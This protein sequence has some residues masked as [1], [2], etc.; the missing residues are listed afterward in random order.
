MRT[1]KIPRIPIATNNATTILFLLVL[2]VD[3]GV[4]D[5]E[6]SVGSRVGL[7]DGCVEGFVLGKH[8]GL[9]VGTKLGM[10]DGR[11]LG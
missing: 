7:T 9:K 1:T 8:D 4:F 2:S 3:T 10:Q 5:D 11:P 6:F